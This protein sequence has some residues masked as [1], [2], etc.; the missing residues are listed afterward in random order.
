VTPEAIIATAR[1]LGVTLLPDGPNIRIRP[2]G[3]LPPN[4]RAALAEQKP[5]LLA[6]LLSAAEACTE[7]LSTTWVAA[8]VN[9]VGAPTCADCLTG[10]T[11]L[12]RAG[13]AL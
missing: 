8:L 2:A 6:I 12:R 13:V 4:V 3:R 11:A 7:C 10:R 9:D 1:E 5:A